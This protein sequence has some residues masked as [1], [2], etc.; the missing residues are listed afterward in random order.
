MPHYLY[1]IYSKKSNKYYVGETY[2]VNR[3]IENHNNHRYE[4]SY[5]KIADDWQ[6]KL[7]Y[8]C[9]NREDALYLESFIKR[10]KSVKF[11]EKI[12]VKSEILSDLISKK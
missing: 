12:I 8:E 11:I 5:S 3:R 2:D 9:A 10:M 1:I 7:C 4:N 6:L